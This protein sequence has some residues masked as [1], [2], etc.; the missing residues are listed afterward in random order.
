MNN[1][2]A[3]RRSPLGLVPGQPIPRLYDRAVECCALGIAESCVQRTR[4]D[5]P[6]LPVGLKR[7]GKFIGHARSHY[8]ES[9][10]RYG[11]PLA[12]L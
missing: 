8:K 2:L 5:Y 7:G 12:V 11:S 6:D 4:R 1:S 10:C 3:D 9:R